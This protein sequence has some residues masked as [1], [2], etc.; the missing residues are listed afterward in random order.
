MTEQFTVNFPSNKVNNLTSEVSS[1]QDNQA[2]NAS[3]EEELSMASEITNKREHDFLEQEEKIN[4]PF[5]GK[6]DF[7][8]EFF[9]NN[10]NMFTP[11]FSTIEGTQIN[12]KGGSTY[13]VNE[14][15]EAPA[16]LQKA[17]QQ[18][19]QKVFS[20]IFPQFKQLFLAELKN[21][22]LLPNKEYSDFSVL[23]INMEQMVEEIVQRVRFLKEGEVTH[24]KLD[25]KPEKLG[26][27][28]VL[29]SMQDK[30]LVLHIFANE[31][32]KKLLDSK[33]N[34]LQKALSEQGFS[35][36]HLEVEV[37]N[38]Q[39]GNEQ[40]SPEYFSLDSGK[41]V[42]YFDYD[43]LKIIHRADIINSID[44]WVSDIMVNY[45]A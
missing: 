19:T 4:F 15:N 35:I 13:I 42:P 6:T 33:I 45:I 8:Q 34:N 26:R 2:N 43:M 38:Q 28:Q 18:T 7:L 27:L 41:K 10:M 36:E 37:S 44:S 1:A 29:L 16:S 25:L 9:G 14:S 24:L 21:T 3:F 40:Q 22:G 17:A 39:K 30:K 23:K 11:S 12:E 20:D 32:A 31:D 5:I